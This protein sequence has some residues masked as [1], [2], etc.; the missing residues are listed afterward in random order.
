MLDKYIHMA[1]ERVRKHP[2]VMIGLVG[3]LIVVIIVL[4]LQLK[5]V[6]HIGRFTNR[7]DYGYQY[8]TDTLSFES[9]ADRN[10][11]VSALLGVTAKAGYTYTFDQLNT[12]A[13]S[14]IISVLEPVDDDDAAVQMAKIVI[15]VDP[16][17]KTAYGYVIK[18]LGH[19][20]QLGSDIERQ[21]IYTLLVTYFNALRQPIVYPINRWTDLLL[22]RTFRTLK[23]PDNTEFGAT[24]TSVTPVPTLVVNNPIPVDGS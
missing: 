20:N 6:I 17:Y 2:M 10:V 1:T 24:A 3:F 19:N 4:T 8:E 18:A 23:A 9:Q 22:I 5:H 15:L 16:T 21:M 11:A 7:S 14:F 13:E 12:L